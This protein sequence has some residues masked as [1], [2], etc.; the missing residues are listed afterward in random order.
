MRAFA[1]ALV[2]LAT[3]ALAA[4]SVRGYVTKSG[5]YV[6]PYVRSKANGAKLDNFSSKGNVNPYTGK[7]GSK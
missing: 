3:P 1:L 5:R 7:K 2:L 6:A 4:K